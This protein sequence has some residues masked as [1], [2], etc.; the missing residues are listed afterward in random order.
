MGEKN[1]LIPESIEGKLFFEKLFEGYKII[2]QAFFLLNKNPAWYIVL[3][4][5]KKN[6]VSGEFDTEWEFLCFSIERNSNV[7]EAIHKVSFRDMKKKEAIRLATFFLY[8][9]KRGKNVFKP[10]T[11]L[12]SGK[13]P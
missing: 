1:N 2:F 5:D 3:H 6:F 10:I 12:T 11:W 4:N 7:N 13:M 9:Y 8:D